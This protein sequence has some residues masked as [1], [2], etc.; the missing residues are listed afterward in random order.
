VITFS[1]EPL[2]V[3]E[4]FVTWCEAVAAGSAARIVGERHILDLQIEEPADATFALEVLE[5]ASRAN[6]RPVPLKRLTYTVSSLD[7]EL[8]G[9][10]R[11]QVRAR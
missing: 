9:R 1:G 7:T 10:V 11:I 3:E 2:P 4:V 8:V 5:E 6:A